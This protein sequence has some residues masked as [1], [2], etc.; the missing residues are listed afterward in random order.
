MQR[1]GAR[2][3][4]HPALA[5]LEGSSLVYAFDQQVDP[6]VIE[7]WTDPLARCAWVAELD[8]G[9]Y[10]VFIEA[11]L[12]GEAER[13]ASIDVGH[14]L[15][16]ANRGDQGD[17]PD[18]PADGAERSTRVRIAATQPPN[19]RVTG[20]MKLATFPAGRIEVGTRGP[21]VVWAGR[22]GAPDLVIGRLTLRAVD[23]A[24]DP[25]EDAPKAA[26]DE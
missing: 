22:P 1:S 8:P 3:I 14:D 17:G 20:R 12:V 5:E 19:E 4:G 15:P 18:E 23:A 6:G 7:G 10:D 25:G 24:G 2:W 26:P 9:A 16:R 11:G 13:S 21:V